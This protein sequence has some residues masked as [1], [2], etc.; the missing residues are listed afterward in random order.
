MACVLNLHRRRLRVPVR[1]PVVQALAHVR[2]G[3]DAAGGLQPAGS[4]RGATRWGRARSGGAAACRWTPAR[5]ACHFVRGT[6]E[7]RARCRA[8]PPPY[9]LP[10]WS[11]RGRAPTTT[12]ISSAC[13]QASSSR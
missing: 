6:R 1:A 10:R 7:C 2:Q 13:P 4:R 9:S 11:E 3:P 8:L 5:H 12:S